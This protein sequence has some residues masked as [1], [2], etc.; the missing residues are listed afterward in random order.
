VKIAVIIG[1][2]FLAIETILVATMFV[3][4]NVGDDAAG[5]GM[6]R[7]FEIVLGPVLLCAAALFIWGQRGGPRPAF[8]AGFGVMAIPLIGI[9][10]SNVLKT[11]NRLDRAQGKAQGAR[12]ADA[13]L[14]RLGRAIDQDDTATVRAILAEGPVDFAA[15]S[16]RGRTVLGRAV[17][18]ARSFEGTPTS[19]ETVRLLLDAGAKPVPNAVEPE[20]Y[21]GDLDAHL[22]VAYVFGGNTANT[23]PLLDLLLTAGADPNTRNY[24]GQPLYFS[25]YGNIPKLDVLAKHGADFTALETTRTDRQGWT[26]AMSAAEMSNWDGVLFL[27]DH[28]VSPTHVAPDG[29]TLQTIVAEKKREGADADSVARV[30]RAIMSFRTK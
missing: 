9:L 14:T 6:A 2:V 24:E 18:H 11:F 8:W 22:L 20:F 25:T 17:E 1:W 13:R 29:K 23:I 3:Q 27:L 16:R 15:R 26:A 30:M 4:P 21:R 5:R 12:F 10:Q 28:G 19:L 7:G